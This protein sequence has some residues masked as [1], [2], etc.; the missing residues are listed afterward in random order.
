MGIMSEQFHDGLYKIIGERIFEKRKLRDDMSQEQLAS[1]VGL[2]R[3]SISKIE[4]GKQ[5]FPVDT[6]YSIANKLQLNVFSLLPTAEEVESYISDLNQ[7]SLFSSTEE[8]EPKE[9]EWLEKIKR[10]S[11]INNG[12]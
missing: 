1:A 9:R 12:N 8:L 2:T 10:N 6:L 4:K 3:S 5:R 7:I 11:L